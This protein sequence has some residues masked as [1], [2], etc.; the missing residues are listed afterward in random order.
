MTATDSGSNWLSL[1]CLGIVF[2]GGWYFHSSLMEQRIKFEVQA[3]IIQQL[4]ETVK[5]LN[6]LQLQINQ[7]QPTSNDQFTNEPLNTNYTTKQHTVMKR[8]TSTT[9]TTLEILRGRDGRDGRDGKAGSRGLTGPP[10]PKGDTGTAG[11]KGEGAGGVVY[12]RWGH[13]SC[14]S[15]E[16]Q[17]VYS[18][19]VGG[20]QWNHQGGGGNPQCLPLDPNYL[21]TI[22][23]TQNHAYMYGAEYEVTNG[24][25]ANSHNT[26]VVCAV[27]YV[28]TRNVVYMLPAKYTCPTGWTREYYGYL[29]SE[30]YVHHRSTF[31]CV[32]HSLTSAIGSSVGND[33]FLFYPVE[34]VCGSLPCPPYEQTKEF[35][36]A[37][38]TK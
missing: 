6:L 38:C 14:P 24:L 1:L 32:D 27:C 28:P 11:P 18:G 17:L 21:K 12:V 29:M 23:G 33:G 22:S 7:H 10:G 20:S 16:A 30:R 13:N 15:T 31:S 8:S 3:E 2:V 5:E 35:S 25:V 34:G 19:R 36:C 26:D 37:V 4:K 9:E